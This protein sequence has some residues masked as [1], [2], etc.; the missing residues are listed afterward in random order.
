MYCKELKEKMWHELMDEA[1]AFIKNP[2]QSHNLNIYHL[3][4]NMKMLDDIIKNKEHKEEYE[5]KAKT[6]DEGMWS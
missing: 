4:C 5:A 1:K 3:L 6:K 2:R